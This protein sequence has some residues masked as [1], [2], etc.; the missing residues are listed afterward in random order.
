MKL[1]ATA[2]MIVTCLQPLRY[3]IQSLNQLS[4]HQRKLYPVL[5]IKHP[6]GIQ[7]LITIEERLCRMPASIFYS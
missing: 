5:R 2:L 4:R 3:A 6:Q 1:L 7:S